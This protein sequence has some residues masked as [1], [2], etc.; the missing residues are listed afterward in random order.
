ML[1][2]QTLRTAADIGSSA[3]SS[4]KEELIVASG[5]YRAARASFLVTARQY[6]TITLFN[7]AMSSI[8]AAV[9]RS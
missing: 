9:S 4:L 6:L 5:C 1:T 2:C 3:L 7:E 8:A